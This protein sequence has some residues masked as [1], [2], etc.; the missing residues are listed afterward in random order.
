MA[1]GYWIVRGSG[2]KDQAA[3]DEYSRMWGSIGKKHEAKIIAGRDRKEP[4]EGPDYAKTLVIEFPSYEQAQAC[5]DDPDYQASLAHACKAF[6]RDL[7][8]VEGVG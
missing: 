8:I 3:Q 7:V 2:V 5:Y 1:K 6:D 4:R